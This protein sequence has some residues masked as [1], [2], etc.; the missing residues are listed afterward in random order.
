MWSNSAERKRQSCARVRR[1]EGGDGGLTI[2]DHFLE[3]VFSASGIKRSVSSPSG[4]VE[5]ASRTDQILSNKTSLAPAPSSPTG[6][7][8]SPLPRSLY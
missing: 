2:R 3:I 7:L 1:D 5:R 6:I 4:R 8:N